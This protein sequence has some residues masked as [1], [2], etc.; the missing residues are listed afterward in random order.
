MDK[1]YTLK[2]IHEESSVEPD[3][4]VMSLWRRL[5]LFM[6]ILQFI[7]GSGAMILVCLIFFNLLGV[8]ELLNITES[9]IT[10]FLAILILVGIVFLTNSAFLIVHWLRTKI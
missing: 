5:Y 10:L 9:N 3:L 2:T 4:V 6:G 7:I 1:S 8:R